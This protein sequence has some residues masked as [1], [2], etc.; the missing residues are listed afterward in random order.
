M[1]AVAKVLTILMVLLFSVS[2]AQNSDVLI[3]LD[4]DQNEHLMNMQGVEVKLISKHLNIYQVSYPSGQRHRR[5]YADLDNLLAKRQLGMVRQPN[6]KLR[7]RAALRPNDPLFDLQWNLEK[8][9]APSL[10]DQTTGGSTPCGDEIVIAVFDDGFDLDHSEFQGLIWSN[11]AEVPNN[12]FDDDNNG[13]VDDYWGLNLE[14]MND[15]HEPDPEYHGPGVASVIGVNSNNNVGSAGLNW[16]IKLM[17]ISSFEKDEALAI[18]AF[19][20]ILDQ[21]KRYNQSGGTEGAY[22]VA[23]NN[24]WGFEGGFEEQFPLLCEMF[25]AM[26]AEGILSVGATENDQVNTD[27]FGDIPSDCS[28]DFLIVVTNTD[29]DDQLSVA[30]FGRENVDLSAPGEAIQVVNRNN[31]NRTNGGTSFAA[32]HVTGAVG[33]LYSLPEGSFCSDALISPADAALSMK[34]FILEGTTPVASL[35]DRTVSGGRLNLSSTVDLI[36]SN[37]DSAPTTLTIYPNP[38]QEILFFDAENM[39]NPVEEYRI[40][41]ALGQL[42]YAGRNLGKGQGIDVAQLPTGVYMITMSAASRTFTGRFL[43]E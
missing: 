2:Q 18:Q 5:Q 39:G 34:R 11:D 40:V 23:V 20:Y 3:R 24:S 41:N 36:T 32:P 7:S 12:S 26:G 19:D 43:K 27:V 30:G 29:Q 42:Q 21:R 15:R 13:V 4:E 1:Q 33:L 17:I 14:T 25:D 6:R 8:I 35:A 22:V 16:N 37:K 31:G 28:S 9:N 38:T 10:W